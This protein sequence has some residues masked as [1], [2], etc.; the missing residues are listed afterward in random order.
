MINI[1]SLILY[2]IRR[3]RNWNVLSAESR[4]GILKLVA[5]VYEDQ[6]G[7]NFDNKGFGPLLSN[8]IQ[9]GIKWKELSKPVRD[10]FFQHIRTRGQFLSSDSWLATF[11][12]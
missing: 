8:L 7:K 3:F 11:H 1:F 12:G 9:T 5:R 2:S 4:E 10:A 6:S